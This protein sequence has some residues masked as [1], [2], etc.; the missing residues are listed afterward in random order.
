MKISCIL[1][2]R[3]IISGAGDREF[4][5]QDVRRELGKIGA[6]GKTVTKEKN[7]YV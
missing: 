2:L 1:L 5:R 7:L 6:I 3:N 4:I